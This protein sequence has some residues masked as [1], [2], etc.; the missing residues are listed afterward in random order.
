[1][2][3]DEQKIQPKKYIEEIGMIYGNIGEIYKGKLKKYNE[4]IKSYTEALVFFKKLDNNNSNKVNFLAL[5]YENLANCYK[6]LKQYDKAIIE[7]KN[8]IK[9]YEKEQKKNPEKYI[10][11]IG[12]IYHNSLGGIYSNELKQYNKAIV[13]YHKALVFYSKLKE[14]N[15]N[16]VKFIA[17]TYENLARNYK[18]LKQYDKAII[19][20]EN[21]L[22]LY[23]EIEKKEPKKYREEIGIIY[24]NVGVIYE[25]KL[26][27]YNKAIES[28]NKALVFFKDL[29]NN[30][31]KK[32]KF[33]TL[34]YSNLAINYKKLEQYDKAIIE[35]E[36][37]LKLYEKEQKEYP[38]KYI[39]EMNYIYN[40]LGN[41]Y[42]MGLRELDKAR[43]YYQKVLQV[44]NKNSSVFTNLY[45]LQIITNQE[46]N[47][48]FEEV[49]IKTYQ[50]KKEEFIKYE[51]LKI[52]K[53]TAQ[54]KKTDIEVWKRKYKG[55]HLG[56]SFKE[57]EEWV[58]SLKD[59]EM[60]KRIE[61][62]FE[63][64]TKYK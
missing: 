40:S 38:N 18:K 28:Y 32:V 12:H 37:K 10:E 19:E 29:D 30:N 50:N 57:L 59:K 27:K 21:K 15:S 47:Q 54:N 17:K 26:K 52:I 4:A 64:F 43:Q 60:K 55:V 3:K 33:M 42:Y 36:N 14:D 53:D 49:Y 11:E 8:K 45:E 9:L 62:V 48:A 20:Y 34:S 56:W 25:K 16:K 61:E 51:M 6:K 63:E 5:T 24:G 13:A 41:L 31:S 35:Y 7:Y 23:E 1:M 22:K 39:V 46:I 44:N 58:K 2:Y